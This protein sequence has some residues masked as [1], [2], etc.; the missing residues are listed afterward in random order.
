ML[1]QL[2]HDSQSCGSHRSV[3]FIHGAVNASVQGFGDHIRGLAQKF[4]WLTTHIRHSN[5]SDQDFMGEHYDSIGYVDIELLKLLLPLDDYDF[6]M[7]GPPPFMESLYEGLKALNIADERIHYEFFGPGATLHKEVGISSLI[8]ELGDQQPV[9]V[10]FARSGIQ[11]SW[12]PSKGTLLDLAESEGLQ[13]AYSCRSGIC[14]TC[15][16]K[17]S[18]G[19]VAYIEP[20]MVDPDGNIALICSSYPRPGATENEQVLPLILDL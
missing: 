1:E 3:W 13:P 4:A 2:V 19:G 20:P 15:A 10:Q 7:C 5:P 6:Y 16:T 11:T 14:Q 9:E 17:I 8:E 12:D 18:Q